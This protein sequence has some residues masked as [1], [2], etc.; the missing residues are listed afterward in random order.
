MLIVHDVYAQVHVALG[1]LHGLRMRLASALLRAAV[2]EGNSWKVALQ[3][4][5][6]L[7]PM[8]EHLYPQ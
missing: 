5:R 8:Y 2:E 1:P 3:A 7:T 6:V 4:A